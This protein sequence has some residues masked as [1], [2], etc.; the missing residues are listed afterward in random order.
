MSV[1]QNKLECCG[2]YSCY[3]ICP[4]NAIEMQFDNEGFCYPEI[5][6]TICINC[7]KCR[8]VCAAITVPELQKYTEIFAAFS[9][10]SEERMTSSSGG[11]FTELAKEVIKFS[12]VVY[13]AA[14]DSNMLVRHIMVDNEKDLV[15]LKGSK[16]VQSAINDVFRDIKIKLKEKRFVLFSGTPCQIAG[17]KNFLGENHEN[18]LCIDLICHGV[19]STMVWK[20]YLEEMFPEKKVTNVN[21]REK[22]KKEKIFNIRYILDDGTEFIEKKEDSL[23]MKGYIQNLFIRPSCFKCKYKGIERCSDIT[24]GDFWAIKEF[25]NDFSDGYGTSSVI[26]HSLQGKM[27]MDKISKSINT[28]SSSTEAVTCWNECLIKSPQKNR[29][30]KKFYQNLKKKSLLQ[31]LVYGIEIKN[32][33]KITERLKIMAKKHLC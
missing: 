16:Y 27:W 4:V 22:N 33:S 31:S 12:G 21:F 9:M 11:V 8:N 2:C 29:K 19:P 15:N 7:N 32:S 25:H 1:L 17:L 26:I 10:D 30:S 18:L 28:I 23:Y 3:N 13:G 24:L 6:E 14:Y 20:R 5:D